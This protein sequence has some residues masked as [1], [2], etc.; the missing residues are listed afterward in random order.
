MWPVAFRFESV[1]SADI[2]VWGLHLWYGV[3]LALAVVLLWKILFV[4]R[5]RGKCQCET[6]L[7][8]AGIAAALSG[9]AV[10]KVISKMTP[11]TLGMIERARQESPPWDTWE[12]T[13]PTAR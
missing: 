4:L 2:L 3:A 9:F 11:D 6:Q 10:S 5:G 12:D 8:R 1:G 13:P 7:D